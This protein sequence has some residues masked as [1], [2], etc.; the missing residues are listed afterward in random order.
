M[1]KAKTTIIRATS[2]AS[3]KVK[4]NYF[5]VEYAEERVVS[6]IE[7]IDIEAE[8]QELWDTVNAEC[9]NQILEIKK[10]FN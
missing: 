7:G 2:R 6:D 9:D 4:D 5:T 1:A 10:S 8:R 3:V